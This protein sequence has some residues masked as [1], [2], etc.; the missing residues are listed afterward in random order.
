MSRIS[1]S[2]LITCFWRVRKNRLALAV[3]VV[4]A[5]AAPAAALAQG[6]FVQIYGT[7]SVDGEYARADDPSAVPRGINGTILNGTTRPLGFAGAG[8]QQSIPGQWGISTNSSNIGF[9]GSEDLWGGL[10]AVFQ[11][12]SAINLDTGNGNLVAVTP[13]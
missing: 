9:R 10:K 2:I 8:F 12:E 7:L 6:S 13:T 4:G 11:L 5:A 1:K 3:A